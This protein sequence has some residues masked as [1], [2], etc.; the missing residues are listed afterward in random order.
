MAARSL[1]RKVHTQQTSYISRTINYN[2]TAATTG[3]LVGYIPAGA[4][5][6]T[7]KVQTTTAF[8]GTTSVTL[9]VGT[10]L[11]GT[12][13]INGTDVRTSTARVDTVVPIA[14]VK[15]TFEATADV[16]IYAS[17]TFGGTTGSAGVAT[18]TVTYEAAVG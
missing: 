10:T 12:D 13:L 8:N 9:S 15:S 5:L 7:T 11:T 16:P 6:G 3:Q 4:T 14:A 1:A 18:V 2:D 17:V